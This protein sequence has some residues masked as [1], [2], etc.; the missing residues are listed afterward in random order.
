MM[1]FE[2]L[3]TYKRISPNSIVVFKVVNM[4]DTF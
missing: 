2:V 3:Q 1:D 4:N